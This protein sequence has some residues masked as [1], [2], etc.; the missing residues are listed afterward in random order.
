MKLL[1]EVFTRANIGPEDYTI[2]TWTTIHEVK[3]SIVGSMIIYF[4]AT[5]ITG[6]ESNNLTSKPIV[7]NAR[8]ID[9]SG[10]IVQI[11]I[12]NRI[13]ES[14]SFSFDSTQKIV[15]KPGD[16]LQVKADSKGIVFYVTILTGLRMA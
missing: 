3:S 12:P 4:S 1:A 13:I 10:N 11:I 16:K 15:M 7:V 8:V 14:E 9:S 5:N 6:S 2:N